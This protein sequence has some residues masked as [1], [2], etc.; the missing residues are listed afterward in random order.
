MSKIKCVAFDMAGTTVQDHKEVETCFANA[1]RIVGLNTTEERILSLQG[2]AKFE[3]FKLLWTEQLG[4]SI[5]II[6]L[7]NQSY[8][9]FRQILEEHYI[10][11][12][13][14]PAEYALEIFEYLKSKNIKI[15]L[16]TGFYRKVADIILEK[17][18][19]TKGLNS[20]YQS[21]SH[22]SLL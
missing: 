15:V 17:L 9:T 2:Y 7:V 18:G 20:N 19:W 8:D 6:P 12:T 3:V 14:F 22:I 16:T 21:N 1:C 11:N 5:G 10:N 4:T 13:I